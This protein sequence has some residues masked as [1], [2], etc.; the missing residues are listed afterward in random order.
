VDLEIEITHERPLALDKRSF[1]SDG[2]L[3]ATECV[4]T[5]AN[6]CPYV[7]REIIDYGQ[8]GLEPDRIYNLYRDAGAL[9]SAASSLNG[10]PLLLEHTAVSAADPKQW[11]T[12]GTVSDCRWEAPDRIV[13]TVSVWNA[14]AIRAIESGALKDLSC[15]Y[16][17]KAVMTS[18]VSPSGEPFDGR[19][20]GP[21]E[22][23]HISLVDMGR[24]RGAMVG[25]AALA[26]QVTLERAI[27]GYG[28]LK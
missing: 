23:N 10:K 16:R 5:R 15:A 6:V 19:M 3:T 12:V 13:G 21:I 28:R 24:V 8:L 2:R 20:V 7:G 26:R 1:D 25:D 17:Y 11:L 27:P 22:W 14:D 9:K 4:L 18:G